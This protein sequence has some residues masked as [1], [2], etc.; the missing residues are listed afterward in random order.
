[1]YWKAGGGGSLEPK[2]GK[3][4]SGSQLNTKASCPLWSQHPSAVTCPKLTA[5]HLGPSRTKSFGLWSSSTGERIHVLVQHGQVSTLASQQCLGGGSCMVCWQLGPTTKLGGG[6]CFQ[7][8]E[9]PL[10]PKK[11]GCSHLLWNSVN[12]NLF[13]CARLLCVTMSTHHRAA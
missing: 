9:G 6:G 7:K 4:I 1:M 12:Q 10:L 11:G 5:T 3:P 8:R 13:T 2:G